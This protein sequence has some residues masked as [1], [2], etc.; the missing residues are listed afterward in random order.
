MEEINDEYKSL[1]KRNEQLAT[2]IEN[3]EEQLSGLNDRIIQL[4]GE[5]ETVSKDKANMLEDLNIDWTRRYESLI[6]EHE[7]RL[8]LVEKEREMIRSQL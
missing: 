3:R 7:H 5:V 8:M 6:E 2:E 1:E 4:E